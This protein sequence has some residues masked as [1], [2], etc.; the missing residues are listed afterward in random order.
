[1]KITSLEVENYR[2]LESV[3]LCFPSAYSAICGPNDSGKT[4]VVRAVRTLVREERPLPSIFSPDPE[5]LSI[6]DDYPRFKNTDPAGRR[7]RICVELVVWRDA[8]AGFYEFLRKQLSLKSMEDAIKLRLETTYKSPGREPD[9]T[10][11][12]FGTDY[13]GLE[14]EEVLRKLRSSNS[15]LVH[16]STRI[17]SDPP[18]LSLGWYLRPA[19][20]DEE[21]LVASMKKTVNRGLAKLSKT[22]KQHLQDLL[23]RLGARYAVNLS[24]PA[25]DFTSVPYSVTLGH[26]SYEVPLENWGSGTKN[27]TL[28]LLSLFR[29]KQVSAADPSASKITPVMIIEE[30]ES[31]LHPA[32][33]AA[34]GRVLQ[35]LAE[36]F[37]VQVIV[38]THS[39]YLLN[40]QDPASNILLERKT[41]YKEPKQTETVDTDGQNWMEPFSHAL[42]LS[43]QE[44]RPWKELILSPSDALLLVEGETDKEYFEL[45]RNGSHGNNRLAFTGDIVSY[46]GTGSLS[47]TVL[48]RFVQNLYR[49]IFVTFD[50]DASARVEKT[51]QSVG[52]RK[53][54]HY[55]PV[56]VAAAGKRSI[57]GLLPEWVFRQVAEGHPALLQ[58]VST[59][60]REEQENAR[61]KLKRLYLDHFKSDAK[62]GPDDYGAFYKLAKVINK[63]L[64]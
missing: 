47:N 1:M 9:V 3:K 38:T 39:P 59:G 35:E 10:V 29:A 21:A 60:T 19:S 18:F 17:E 16:N 36:D 28:I 34:F 33:Q 7:I 24:M 54:D 32:A 53:N 50:L 44:F 62:P 43:S 26:K 2:T 40:L 25:F 42:G 48:L 12:A 63:A 23:G 45:L 27:R 20:Q 58:Q 64:I 11:K 22:H 57:E 6:K 41:Y 61:K 46:E 56:G 37:Q 13:S 8:D 4:N 30:P 51:L 55:A 31:F 5:Q 49:R 52:L 14:A 15:I